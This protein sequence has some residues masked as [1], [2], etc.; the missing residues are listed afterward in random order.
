M[1]QQKKIHTALGIVYALL[2]LIIVGAILIGVLAWP[3]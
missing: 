1:T 2:A 3:Y